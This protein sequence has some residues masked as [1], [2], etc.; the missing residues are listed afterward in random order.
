MGSSTTRSQS[1]RANRHR[2][3][4]T[5]SRGHSIEYTWTGRKV[6]KNHVQISLLKVHADARGNVLRSRLLLSS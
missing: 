3:R 6:V 1:S 4:G 2:S 5:T